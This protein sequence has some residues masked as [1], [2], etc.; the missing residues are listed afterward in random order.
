MEER[1]GKWWV[2]K[3]IIIGLALIWISVYKPNWNLWAIIGALLI[4]KALVILIMPLC[5]KKKS[6]ITSKKRR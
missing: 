1:C 2:L 6:D 4:I 3:L 5:C